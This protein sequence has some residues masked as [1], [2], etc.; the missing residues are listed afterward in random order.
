MVAIVVVVI[1]I[2]FAYLALAPTSPI[3]HPQVI[4]SG[5]VSTSLFTVPTSVTFN[6]NSGSY[7]ASV[8]SNGAY[9]VGVPDYSNYTVV[10]DWSSTVQ[11]KSGTCDVGTV[12]V[13]T[14]SS[15]YTYNP[16]C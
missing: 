7:K 13:Y 14:A 15:S 2:A 1:I 11:N 10:I 12:S 8:Q 5:H 3:T 16:S 9:S 6:G 4:V